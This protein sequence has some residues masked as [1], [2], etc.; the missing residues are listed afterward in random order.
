M[1]LAC[2]DC[3]NDYNNEKL[4][5][6]DKDGENYISTINND[7]DK[8][9]RDAYYI[10]IGK[11]RNNIYKM[12]AVI[13]SQGFQILGVDSASSKNTLK[14]IKAIEIVF[15]SVQTTDKNEN[16]LSYK[17][18]VG[19]DYLNDAVYSISSNASENQTMVV[20]VKPDIDSASK[21][22]KGSLYFE[23]QQENST[24]IKKGETNT[25]QSYASQDEYR[26]A[27]NDILKSYIKSIRVIY[28]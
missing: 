12:N 3:V 26:N 15:G 9:F 4:N 19:N 16:I 27:K 21:V 25:E 5:L 6:F 7:Y 8:N 18:K 10:A 28:K 2:Y 17:V 22:S 11:E 23:V 13:N 20:E 14:D 1:N 24:T